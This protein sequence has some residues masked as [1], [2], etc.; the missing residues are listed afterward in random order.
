LKTNI[1]S[2]IFFRL[3]S[4]LIEFLVKNLPNNNKFHS[5]LL[6]QRLRIGHV[7]GNF[8]I[9]EFKVN[10]LYGL[11]D[12]LKEIS[13]SKNLITV[14]IGS[15][16]GVSS[17]LISKYCKKLYCVD[18]FCED[19]YSARFDIVKERCKNIIKIK[20]D[21]VKAAGDFPD[22]F[23]DLVYIDA[24]HLFD[25]VVADILAWLPKVKKKGYICGHDYMP[26]EDVIKA[27]NKILGKPHKVYSDSS[28]LIKI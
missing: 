15:Y 19:V 3:K 11:N 5:F 4:I 9:N 10:R 8:Q 17:E 14:E 22:A 13:P 27:V 21:S 2:K 20:S 6:L 7:N 23:F 25:D 28:W 26:H 18:L 24:S 12:L 1:T 16:E